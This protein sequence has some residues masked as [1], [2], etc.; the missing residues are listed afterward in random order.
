MGNYC[1]KKEEKEINKITPLLI[2]KKILYE[3]IKKRELNSVSDFSIEYIQNKAISL[4]NEALNTENTEK[5]Y[6]L[7]KEALSYDNTNEQI[8]EEY[9]KTEKVCDI[10]KYNE[11]IIKFYYNISPETYIKITGDKKVKSSKDL[12]LEIFDI[13]KNYNIEEKQVNEEFQEKNKI[14]NYFH[15]IDGKKPFLTSNFTFSFNT[16]LELALYE[17]YITLY[18]IIN[19]KIDSLL[20]II[21]DKKYT[22]RQKTN[23]ICTDEQFD[24]IKNIISEYKINE[25][26]AILNFKKNS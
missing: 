8:L 18:T 12:L 3:N 4:Y 24:E 16:N 14:K 7:L 20:K 11:N 25:D 26:I 6:L 19:N 22:F 5:K 15:N 1:F 2:D 10:Y 21:L 23:M 17:L 9:L 13:L